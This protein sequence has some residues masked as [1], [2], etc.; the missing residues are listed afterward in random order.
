MDTV[1]IAALATLPPTIAALTA[2]WLA[3]CETR[4]TRMAVHQVH[5]L[6]NS[7][8]DELLQTVSAAAHAR[9]VFD[10]HERSKRER[11]GGAQS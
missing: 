1:I 5:H 9:G 2:A 3:W 8:L 10:E 6:V 7:R 11:S 4:K